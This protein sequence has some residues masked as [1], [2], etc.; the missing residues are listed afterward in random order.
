MYM[1]EEGPVYTSEAE[2]ERAAERRMDTFDRSMLRGELTQEQYNQLVKDLD[3]WC[4][5]QY[6]KLKV[7]R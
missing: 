2:I 3:E 1:C 4:K 5:A 6:N 7:I